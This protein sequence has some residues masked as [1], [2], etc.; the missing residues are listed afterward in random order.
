MAGEL[1]GA[2]RVTLGLDSAKFEDGLK[3]SRARAQAETKSIQKSLDGLKGRFDALAAGFAGSAIVAAGKKALDYASSLG[4]VAQQLGV[5]TRELQEYRY[6]ASQAGVEQ[7]TMDAGLAKLTRT[8]GEAKAGSKAQATVF[9]ELGVAVQ[10]ASGRVY[11][12]GEVIPKLADA[13]S[14]IKD[15][16]T[17]ARIEVDLFGKAGQKLDTLLAGG[18]SGVNELRDAAQKLGL[19]L[20]DRQIQNADDTA[21]KLSAL[22]QVLEA[23]IAGTVADNAN[24]ILG[25]ANALSKLSEM[26]VKAATEYP[27]ATGV[28]AGAAL[29]ARF[30]PTG[31]MVG[32]GLGFVAGESTRGPSRI[33]ARN[34]RVASASGLVAKNNRLSDAEKRLAY[35][36]IEQK[37]N[38]QYGIV[39]KR[40]AFDTLS[41]AEDPNW[42]PPKARTMT[43]PALA[44][45]IPDG[46]LPTVVDTG[47]TKTKPK[48]ASGPSAADRAE[49]YSQEQSNLDSEQLGLKQQITADLRLRA[50]FEHER[51]QTEKAAYEFDLDTKVKAAQLNAA[52]AER[53][54]ITNARNAELQSTAVNWQLDDALIR[55]EVD[56]RKSAIQTQIEM[57]QG[58]ANLARTAS[59]RRAVEMKILDHQ[60]EMERLTLRAVQEAKSSTP[61]EKQVA[62]DREAEL[63]ALRSSS[64]AGIERSNLS[65]LAA[66][67]DSLPRNAAEVNEAFENIAANGIASMTDGL[68]ESAANVLKLKG[69][70]GQLFNQ[71]IADVIRLQVRQTLGG[72]GGILGKLFGAG[73]ALLGGGASVTA[74]AATMNSASVAALGSGIGARAAFSSLP[75]LA[76][77]GSFMAGGVG[78]TD[79]NVLSIGGVPRVKVSANERITVSPNAGNDNPGRLAVEV[80]KGDLFDVIVRGQASQVVAGAAPAIASAGSQHAQKSIARRQSRRLA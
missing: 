61:G 49:N 60:I 13:L 66:Y 63:P 78:G 1:I 2:L 71:I 65:P 12:A 6:A 18:S 62:A 57:L 80:V 11:S 47:G 31:A 28:I 39:E 48:G 50:S 77:G 64:V 24:A 23:R 36:R 76:R 7:D 46:A 68:A 44:A 25:L 8:I 52:D 35:R 37:A 74:S 22:K 58:Q 16:A 45:I 20:S 53:L 27:R 79:R 4:E 70:A 14:R 33:D 43:K 17:R 55:E 56:L 51:I 69:V 9:R 75:G 26:A 41:L 3:K 21:D 54:K 67:F 29:G 10:D 40:G 59:E 34:S 32:A 5:T 72:G 73:T 42:R 15:P 30:G 38:A 19:V